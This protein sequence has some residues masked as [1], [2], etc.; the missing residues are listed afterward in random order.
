MRVF[1]TYAELKSDM[2]RPEGFRFKPE[3]GPAG[4]VCS[5]CEETH[6]FSLGGI[7]GGYGISAENEFICYQC[8][9][10]R[11]RAEMDEKGLIYLYLSHEMPKGQYRR[12]GWIPAGTVANWPGSLK[13]KTG[14]IKIGS[15]NMAGR[16]F[17]FWFKDHRGDEWHGVQI[18]DNTQIA[19][20]RRLKRKGK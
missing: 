11:D 4:F 15:H 12:Q 5:D 3:F 20:C 2:E 7:T 10:K 17:D 18:G 16:R 1:Q 9:A 8:C 6:E 13:Y 14:Q 19:R